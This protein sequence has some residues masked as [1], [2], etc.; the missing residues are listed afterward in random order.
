MQEVITYIVV[1]LA[2]VFLVKK[3]FFKTKKD[4]HCSTDC[5]CD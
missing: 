2:V 3:F 5:N 4:G 1:V